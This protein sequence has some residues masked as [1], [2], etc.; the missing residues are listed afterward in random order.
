MFQRLLVPVDGS[1]ASHHAL[2]IAIGLARDTGGHLHLIHV[3][4]D[5]AYLAGY[6]PSGAA[7]GEL[8]KA[9]RDAGERILQEA[10]V[11]VKTAGLAV[12]AELVDRFGD[13]LPQAVAD[14][15][16]RWKADLI[17]VGTHGRRGMSRLMLGS[18]AD[19]IIR[20]APV[21]VLVARQPDAAKVADAS[22]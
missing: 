1:E 13:R 9:T 17:V 7:A 8:Y 5:A 21:P 11:I 15:A 3:V 2:S 10:E 6:D 18:G 20:M 14:A 4:E 16:Q 12:E 22:S 19:Q